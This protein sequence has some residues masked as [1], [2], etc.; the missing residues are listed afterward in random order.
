MNERER[1]AIAEQMATEEGAEAA[2]IAIGKEVCEAMLFDLLDNTPPAH[3]RVVLERFVSAIAGAFCGH[4]GHE[5][6]QEALAEVRGAIA[7][8]AKA[9]S[10]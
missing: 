8:V 2:G 6:V 7:D 1:M 9:R 3:K 5:A 10:N 4:I